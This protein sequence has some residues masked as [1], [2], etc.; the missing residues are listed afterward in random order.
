MERVELG[1]RVEDRITH[2]R[3]IAVGV[4]DWMYA[5]RRI[6]VQPETPTRDKTQPE[7]FCVDEPQLSVLEKAVIQAP[8]REP[9][10]PAKTGGDRQDPPRSTVRGL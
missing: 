3:G 9:A 2:L 7:T 8:K 5:C 6:V 4:T 10:A 1:D